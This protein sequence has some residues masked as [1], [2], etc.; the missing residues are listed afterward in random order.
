MQEQARSSLVNG[1]YILDRELGGGGMGTVYRAYDRLTRKYV[2]LKRV[3]LQ[4]D[5]TEGTTVDYGTMTNLYETLAHE[6]QILA[7]LRHPYI[8]DVLDYGFDDTR[9]PYFTMSLVPSAAPFVKVAHEQPR[10]EQVRLLIQLLQAI[11]YLHIRGLL[12][13]DLKPDNALVTDTMQVKVLDF[14]LATLHEQAKSDE[15][16][17]TLL[18]MAPEILQGQAPSRA[19]D[20]YAFGVMLY[21]TLKGERPFGQGNMS[22]MIMDILQTAVSTEGVEDELAIIIERLL[23]KSADDR[24]ESAE[25][26]IISL[27]DATD[28]PIPSETQEI[29]ESFLQSAP[30][31]GRSTEIEELVEA[32]TE[33]AGGTGS[34]WLIGGET[35]V[36]KSRLLDELRIKGYVKDVLVLQGKAEQS[37]LPYQMWRDPLRRFLLAQDVSDEQISII[38]SILPDLKQLL[39]RP[40]PPLVQVDQKSYQQRLNDTIIA[41]F[42]DYQEPVLLILDDLQWAQESLPALQ[43]LAD[44]VTDL[45]LMIVAT[46]RSDEAPTL[47][48]TLQQMQALSLPR[49]SSQTIAELSTAILGD[50]GQHEGIVS[51]LHEHS[52]G[53]I[54]FMLEILRALAEESGK[55]RNINTL[56]LPDQIFTGGIKQV[57]LRRWERVPVEARELLQTAAL[58]GREL[59]LKVLTVCSPETDIESWLTLCVNSAVLEGVDETWHF[60]HDKLREA[61]IS[62]LDANQQRDVNRRLAEAIEA[63]YPDELDQAAN[64]ARHWGLAGNTTKEYPYRRRATNHLLQIGASEDALDEI[65]RTLEILPQVVADTAAQQNAR[66]EVLIQAA[67]AHK[68]LSQL[69]EALQLLEQAA[70]LTTATSQQARIAL[71]RSD[72]AYLRGDQDT[73]ITQGEESLARYRELQDAQGIATMLRQLGAIMLNKG[74][75]EQANHY[76]QEGLQISETLDDP[77][78]IAGIYNNLSIIM[79]RKGDTATAKQYLEEA[80][81]RWQATGEQ[82][83]QLQVLINLGN[84]HAMSDEFPEAEAIYKDGL[85]IADRIGEQ[86]LGGMAINN[87]G[88]VAMLTEQFDEASYYFQ[89]TLE[90][91]RRIGAQQAAANALTNLGHTAAYQQNNPLA[92][93]YF[94]EAIETALAA[95]AVPILLEALVGLAEITDNTTQARQWLSSLAQHPA[96]SGGIASQIQT[97]LETINQKVEAEADT[98]AATS[99]E[100]VLTLETIIEQILAMW[101]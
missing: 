40:V 41:L 100:E 84:I 28:T 80:K 88:M 53:N 73:A 97:A 96:A 36:G 71:E 62:T 55:L 44:M 83:K 43:Q 59:D 9:Q 57:M 6:F 92:G 60:S 30:F 49:I 58:R 48:E 98:S 1:R 68:N 23:A 86:H 29:R 61:I 85:T 46:Y 26:V 101:K 93:L 65:K 47:P 50:E 54:Y 78:L 72:I 95:N 5:V 69:D 15:I 14:G 37:G 18:Y 22:N 10:S 4:R 75:L 32:L 38:G 56:Q 87:L 45:P 27:C 42:R 91:S 52:E 2:A 3:K 74:E 39:D 66:V 70:P 94:V 19:S 17:G 64:L 31:I 67:Q 63:T 90:Q 77:S 81:T 82:R 99:S 89:R 16:A 76:L 33:A 24:Y 25:Q 12:H 20:L 21:E 35:G 51:Y 8:I 7:A 34:A 13:R 79:R 11:D